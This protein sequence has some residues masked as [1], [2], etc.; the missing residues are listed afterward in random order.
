V[1]VDRQVQ[2]AGPHRVIQ[3]LLG[4]DGV[5][6]ERRL[7]A[8]A[9]AELLEERLPGGPGR[10]RRGDVGEL[11]AREAGDEL[12]LGVL[13]GRQL[14]LDHGTLFEDQRLRVGDIDA[15]ARRPGHAAGQVADEDGTRFLVGLADGEQ[16]HR[17]APLR[18]VRLTFHFEVTDLAGLDVGTALGG[19]QDQEAGGLFRGFAAPGGAARDPDGGVLDLRPFQGQDFPGD[20]RNGA[21]QEMDRHL[22]AGKVFLEV[23]VAGGGLRHFDLAHLDE[24]FDGGGAL[25]PEGAVDRVGG[26]I[27]AVGARAVDGQLAADD[28]EAVLEQAD[29]DDAAL[30]RDLLGG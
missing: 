23:E 13:Q 18:P 22:F 5:A 20:G 30:G 25:D 7:V 12:H 3:H 8:P 16:Q 2:A 4:E 14:V 24:G 27:E 26:V 28:G 9:L 11:H 15:V 19:L 1:G 6:G 17:L 29:G 21:V 10:Q